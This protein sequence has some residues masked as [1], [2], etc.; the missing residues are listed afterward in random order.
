[1]NI[2]A[3]Y[4]NHTEFAKNFATSFS[5][6]I[7]LKKPS[8]P[9]IYKKIGLKNSF[10]NDINAINIFYTQYNGSSHCLNVM[11]IYMQQ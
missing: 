11:K 7:I 1:V 4:N 3:E 2:V 8:N 9:K 6:K 10:F 5:Y